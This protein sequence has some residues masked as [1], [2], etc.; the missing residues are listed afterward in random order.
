MTDTVKVLVA[1]ALACAGPLAPPIDAQ[2]KDFIGAEACRPCHSS[3]FARQ[4]ATGHARAL[5]RV[6]EHP[7]AAR[8]TTTEPLLRAPNF[9]FSFVTVDD[10]LHV[11]A[12]DGRF[13]TELPLE[14]AFGAGEHAVTFVSRVSDEFYLEHSFSYYPGAGT[15][16][17]TPRHDAL[18][19]TTLNQAMGQPIR[20]QGGR[21][22]IAG[23]FGCH[24]TGPVLAGTGGVI[25]V[26]EPGVHCET[27]HG[28]GGGHRSAAAAG[29]TDGAKKL[30]GRPGNL[31]AADLNRFC[32]ECHRNIA[33]IAD[34]ENFD[35]SS[36]WSVRHQ[37]PY[38]A[39]SRCF[40]LSGGALSCL[41]CHEPHDRV[42]RGD[43]AYYRSKCVACHQ[44][45]KHPPA[46][47]CLAQKEPDCAGCHMPL[48]AAGANM[49]FKNH[50]IGIYPK[51]AAL[52]PAR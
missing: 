40:Q 50:W 7:L 8:F 52:K 39:R 3:Q 49:N 19:A 13:V 11:R 15:F 18:P 16:A 6:M 14:W 46:K 48:V 5:R 47:T 44:A 29:D 45:E 23:C 34:G 42:R 12:D 38:L 10:G 20:T 26:T 31:S 37:P 28:A 27:C 51:G 9:R 24:S 1:A 35:W 4:S 17:L 41:T 2:L 36:P 30:I 43:A 25:A 22:T 21:A 32:G 33:S